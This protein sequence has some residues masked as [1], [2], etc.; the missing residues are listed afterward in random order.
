MQKLPDL[1]KNEGT[2]SVLNFLA[3]IIFFVDQECQ[4]IWGNREAARFFNLRQKELAGKFCYQ[5]L[6]E[7][8]ICR[9]CPL[10]LAFGTGEIQS[11]KVN[12]AVSG[13]LFVRGIPLEMAG[14]EV[15]GLLEVLINYERQIYLQLLEE[16]K[17]L[18]SSNERLKFALKSADAGLWEYNFK[19]Q[20]YALT[21]F[22]PKRWASRSRSIPVVWK[23]CWD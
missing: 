12:S 18:K 1:L 11:G 7:R 10:S 5:L 23:R 19:E 3:R 22:W 8:E 9:D 20:K 16:N 15:I 6:G 4:I 2:R 13:M 17:E 14:G 21:I